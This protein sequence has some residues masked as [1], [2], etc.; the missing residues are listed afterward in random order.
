MPQSLDRRKRSLER[1]GM[2]L[3]ELDRWIKLRPLE[4]EIVFKVTT[5]G[6]EL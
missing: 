6:T 3:I 2:G 5:N 1:D 4:K